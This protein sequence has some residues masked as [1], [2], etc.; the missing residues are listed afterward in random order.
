MRIVVNTNRWIGITTTAPCGSPES[1]AR[2]TNLLVHGWTCAG[3]FYWQGKVLECSLVVPSS[4]LQYKIVG[5]KMFHNLHMFQSPFEPE[6][7]V[8]ESCSVVVASHTVRHSNLYDQKS[9]S[10]PK[11]GC[12]GSVT[13]GRGL[14]P[15]PGGLRPSGCE[16]PK[17]ATSGG[18]TMS[19][20]I[21]GWLMMN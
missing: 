8:S 15:H 5:V 7:Q 19:Q 10:Q 16:G 6:L 12:R 2:W 4:T 3:G 11:K 18:M 17:A 20:W 1:W 14:L 21:L 9:F 13:A